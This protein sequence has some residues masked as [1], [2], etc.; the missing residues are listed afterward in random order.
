MH[1]WTIYIY[2]YSCKGINLLHTPQ[3]ILGQTVKG[4]P[5]TFTENKVFG[6][7]LVHKMDMTYVNCRVEIV[8]FIY[9][10]TR[11]KNY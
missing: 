2:I 1:N 11:K 3:H 6:S 4:H 5:L 7:S 8:F 9:I 10:C